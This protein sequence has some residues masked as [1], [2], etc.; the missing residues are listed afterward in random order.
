MYEY[1]HGKVVEVTE[2][3]VVIDVHGVGYKIWIPSSRGLPQIGEKVH[4]FTS[5]VVREQ[6][7]TLYGFVEKD[8]R[9]LF[10]LLITL[11]GIGPKTALNVL[12]HFSLD[13]FNAVVQD[14]SA[15]RLAKV[16][17]IGKKTAERLL[18]DLKGR[19][20]IAPSAGG[21]RHKLQDALNAL[22]NLGYTQTAAESAVKKAAEEVQD[23]NDLSSLIT[24]ALKFK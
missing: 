13:D 3:S 6:S 14:Q 19:I 23:P 20:K 7:Q 21:K 12:A 22:L 8:E 9:A 1:I 18:V 10:E 4:L 15:V 11:S 16:P 24:A 2:E 5:W 17:G